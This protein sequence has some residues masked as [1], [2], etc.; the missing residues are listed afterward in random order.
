V[1]TVTDGQWRYIRNLT[2]SELFI[3]KHLM[4]IQGNAVLNNPYW[5]TWVATAWD[6]PETYR[7]VKRYMSRPPEELYHT[8]ADPY[9]MRNLL[10]GDAGTDPRTGKTKARLCAELDRWLASQ[11][12]P[13]ISQDTHEAHQAAKRGEHLYFPKP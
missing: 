5:P 12:D 10:L 3:E 2:S 11:S 6:R 8:A 1:R 7:L 9:E 4:G 13:G